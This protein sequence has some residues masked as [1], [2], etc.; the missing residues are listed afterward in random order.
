MPE[1]EKEM[2][3]GPGKRLGYAIYTVRAFKAGKH[4]LCESPWL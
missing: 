2:P 4:V 3:E 1:M